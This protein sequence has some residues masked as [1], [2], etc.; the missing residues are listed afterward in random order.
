MG[1]LLSFM[2]RHFFPFFSCSVVSV[3]LFFASFASPTKTTSSEHSRSSPNYRPPYSFFLTYMRS[4]SLSFCRCYLML[5]TTFV[6]K[7]TRNIDTE[8]KKGAK[9][10]GAFV[11][12]QQSSFSLHETNNTSQS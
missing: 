2:F 5:L 11:F 6:D 1:T 3:C 7:R 12:I 9:K 4:P 10:K 8:R